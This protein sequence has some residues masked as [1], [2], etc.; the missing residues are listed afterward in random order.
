MTNVIEY[1]QDLEL[2]NFIDPEALKSIILETIL[3]STDQLSSCVVSFAYVAIQKFISHCKDHNIDPLK[4]NFD[5]VKEFVDRHLKKE[6]DREMKK[7][8][9]VLEH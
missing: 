4:M 6:L 8:L 9:P 7:P 3:Q 5:E 2:E 1:Q